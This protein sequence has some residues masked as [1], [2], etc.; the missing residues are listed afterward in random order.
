MAS[1]QT[2]SDQA[3][4]ASEAQ[5]EQT[6]GLMANR[7]FVKLWTG[8]TV[9]LVGTQVTQ[10][11]MPL[12]A[13]LTLHATVLEVGILNALRFVPVLL[14]SLFAGVWLDRRRRRP[15]LICCALG[16]ALLIGLVPIASAVGVLSIGLLFVVTTLVGLLN[17]VFDVGALSYVPQLVDRQHL[18]QANGR[19]QA[20]NAIAGIVGPGLAGLLI[21]LITAPITLSADAVSYLASAFGLISVVRREPEPETPAE[22]Q[23]VTRSIAEGLRAVFGS[24]VL[25]SLLGQ[26]T[27]LNLFFG[28]MFTVFLVYAVRYLHLTAFKLGLVLGAAAVGA[29]IGATQ[30]TRFRLALGLGRGMAVNT[31]IM[32]AA[33]LLLLIPRGAGVLT[34]IILA[35]SHFLYGINIAMF[36][37]TA[38][39]MRQT[40][41][42]R[43][44][45]ARMNASYRMVLWGVPLF[46]S[47]LGGVLGEVAGLRLALV[48][49]VVAMISPVLWIFFSPVFR[50]REMP[51]GPPPEPAPDPK[52]AR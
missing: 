14:L 8:Q 15:I 31:A 11:A 29:L 49:S 52:E 34:V 22:R 3:A 7:D 21:G 50:L 41:T 13:V 20:S 35:C 36:N 43:P 39:T 30:A 5:A 26:S 42:P 18:S 9:S 6:S 44:L 4:T 10:L 1:D 46:G 32:A 51:S 25:R 12:V 37:V 47:L 27:A 28:S 24:G 33:P 16:N 19:L 40:V 2:V 23:S 17:M 38:I 48:I 45:L